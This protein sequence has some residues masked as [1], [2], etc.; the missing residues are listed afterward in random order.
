MLRGVVF[1]LVT[2]VSGNLLSPVF[3]GEAAFVLL[4]QHTSRRFGKMYYSCLKGQPEILL[5][6]P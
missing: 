3:N 6:E 2:V 5:L 4:F 1:Y